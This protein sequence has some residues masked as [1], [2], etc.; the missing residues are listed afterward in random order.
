MGTHN[1][2]SCGEIRKLFTSMY[3]DLAIIQIGILFFRKPRLSL[4][5]HQLLK[6]KGCSDWQW[7]V[8]FFCFAPS[9]FQSKDEDGRIILNNFLSPI[10]QNRYLCKQCKSRCHS[11]FG[12][13]VK[14]LF[15]SVDMS[16]FNAGRPRRIHFRNSGW[17]RLI[18]A[19]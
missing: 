8:D 13:R 3:L 12:F 2:C 4:L 11:I 19:Q 9:T 10:N 15:T 7:Y 6:S 5:L 14:P 16:K 17:R 18:K 1:I